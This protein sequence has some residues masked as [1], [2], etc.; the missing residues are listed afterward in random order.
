M[1]NAKSELEQMIVDVKKKANNHVAVNR[2]DEVNIMKAMLNDPQFSLGIYDKNVGYIG[3]RCP[4]DEAVQFVK[5]VVSGATGLDRKESEVL[6]K[7]YEFTKRDANYMLTNMRD[8]I[9]VYTSTGR[10]INIMQTANTEAYLYT[11]EQQPTKKQ[12]PDKEHPGSSK[13]I[14][15]AAYTKLVSATRCPKYKED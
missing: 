7:N 14:T 15:T 1:E 10:K 12:V 5:N 6:A 4:H 13:P 9:T 3:Q 11:K 2:V 8:F